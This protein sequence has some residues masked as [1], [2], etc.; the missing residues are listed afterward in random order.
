MIGRGF[1]SGFGKGATRMLELNEQLQAKK[2]ARLQDEELEK[3]KLETKRLLDEDKRYYEAAQQGFM[4]T[5]E[6]KSLIVPPELSEDADEVVVSP[7]LK[8]TRMIPTAR[9]REVAQ[10]LKVPVASFIPKETPKFPDKKFVSVYYNDSDNKLTQEGES[11]VRKWN[12]IYPYRQITED[13]LKKSFQNILKDD[14]K[15]S[16]V[17]DIY[18]NKNVTTWVRLNPDNLQK[19][20]TKRG[21]KIFQKT[22]K[23]KYNKQEFIKQVFDRREALELKRRSDNLTGSGQIPS[24][25]VFPEFSSDFSMPISSDKDINYSNPGKNFES[26]AAYLNVLNN[27]A[28]KYSVFGG[29]GSTFFNKKIQNLHK[30][31]IKNSL[32]VLKAGYTTESGEKISIKNLLN[33]EEYKPLRE[34]YES[35]IGKSIDKNESSEP[36]IELPNPKM[37]SILEINSANRATVV[38][39]QNVFEKLVKTDA[40]NNFVG[41]GGLR[42]HQKLY[43]TVEGFVLESSKVKEINDPV[44]QD[45][46]HNILGAIVTS[47]IPHTKTIQ[48][49]HK[50]IESNFSSDIMPDQTRKD[51]ETQSRQNTKTLQ[52]VRK[53]DKLVDQGSEKGLDLHTQAAGIW[54]GLITLKKNVTSAIGLVKIST[55]K[56]Q[57]HDE[58]QKRY[59]EVTQSYIA[60]LENA[61]VDSDVIDRFSQF[62]KQNNELAIRETPTS[63]DIYKLRARAQFVKVQ[64]AYNLAGLFQGGGT[65][66]RTISDQDFSIIM[67]ALDQGSS[68]ALK[69]SLDVLKDKLQADSAILSYELATGKFGIH[70]FV[71]KKLT[72]HFTRYVDHKENIRKKLRDGQ[73]VEENLPDPKE[74]LKL[75]K[76]FTTLA[77]S[78]GENMSGVTQQSFTDFEQKI[79]FYT[80]KDIK[81]PELT[82]EE[83]R[84]RNK[85]LN[86]FDKNREKFSKWDDYLRKNYDNKEPSDYYKSLIASSDKLI[87]SKNTEEQRQGIA[88]KQQL[89][90]Q[91]NKFF[92]DQEKLD[93]TYFLHERLRKTAKRINRI[94]SLKRDY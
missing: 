89:K 64:L 18:D 93:N 30:E 2:A 87:N 67:E 28:K 14:E 80:R 70:N 1:L 58:I 85:I 83:K 79:E 73:V 31:K 24:G 36:K 40:Y 90:N 69:Q 42:G 72:E 11:Y 65:G 5:H 9:T 86:L 66:S 47:T 34:A 25:T 8:Y 77:Q 82:R 39:H 45:A 88:I 20:L 63:E 13:S 41:Q 71:R 29:S 74:Q 60:N 26:A 51:I 3:K 68:S 12:Q 59:N 46:I 61:E 37:Q 6:E 52:L 21:E 23:D 75:W 56:A 44:N 19:E 16:R 76:R 84:I 38:S 27:Y 91:Q 15:E 53:L 17:K 7:E 55:G 48:R 32:A 92:K 54:S 62:V 57:G 94:F 43:A 78:L 81:S 49:G 50:T 22:F 4:P 35:S 33:S 10:R